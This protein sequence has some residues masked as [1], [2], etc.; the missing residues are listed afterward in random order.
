[1]WYMLTVSPGWAGQDRTGHVTPE[2]DA[3][4][5]QICQE[6]TQNSASN[7]LKYPSWSE[8]THVIRG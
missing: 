2:L 4:V 8:D 5:T 7:F 6:E 3:I 1:M